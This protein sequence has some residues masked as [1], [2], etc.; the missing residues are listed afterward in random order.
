MKI[1]VI[2]LD[3]RPCNHSWVTKYANFANA[4]IAIIPSHLCGNLHSGLDK[5]NLREW[6]LKETKNSD[7]LLV[8]GDALTSGGLI[9]ARQAKYQIDEVMPYVSL[10]QEIKANF[11]NIKIYVF[12]TIMRTSITTYNKRTAIYWKQINEYSKVVGKQ[13][14]HP[15]DEL[16]QR[17]KELENEIPSAVLKTYLQAR[18]KK[19]E[20][21]HLFFDLALKGVIDTL[22]LLQEDSMPYGIQKIESEILQQRI[23]KE[24]L[25]ERVFL[26]NGAD[27]GSVVLLAKIMVETTKVKPTI[28]LLV[29]SDE[30]KNQILPFEDRPIYENYQNLLKVIGF[31]ETN[32]NDADYILSMYLEDTIY[33]LDLSD[34]TPIDVKKDERYHRFITN[35][36]KLIRNGRQVAF[37]DLLHPNGG[38]LSLLKDLDTHH[39]LTYSAW[40]T[41]TNSLGSC[42]ALVGIHACNPFANMNDFL[43]E[44]I[45]DDCLYQTTVRRDLNERYLK[46]GFNIHDLNLKQL[47]ATKEIE[48]ELKELA[49]QFTSKPFQVILPWSRT[50]EIDI[51]ME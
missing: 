3:S 35:T 42:L 49:L 28:H 19:K 9:Q 26:Y 17:R 25:Q 33:D 45:I 32:I 48:K 20:L 5:K 24:N 46:K 4:E 31:Q 39:L 34:S 6:L 16:S 37:V 22:V 30:L 13:Y 36:N 41:A 1:T 15:S 18:D 14:F 10:L 38:N 21:N 2:P 47:D 7:Y 44:R 50:F 23:I 43:Y 29:P 11:P 40:N 8:S 12:D 27:E 51:D